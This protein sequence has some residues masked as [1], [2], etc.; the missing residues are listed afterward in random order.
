MFSTLDGLQRLHSGAIRVGFLA[1]GVNFSLDLLGS[2]S[3][4]FRYT[5]VKKYCKEQIESRPDQVRV[6]HQSTLKGIFVG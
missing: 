3:T 6:F 4:G 1:S 5:E 2:F